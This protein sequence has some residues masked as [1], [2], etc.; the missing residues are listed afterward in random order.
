VVLGKSSLDH[1]GILEPA[2]KCGLVIEQEH[3]VDPGILPEPLDI[4]GRWLGAATDDHKEVAVMRR[5]P[6]F[7]YIWG[8]QVHP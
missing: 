4:D 8:I 2:F 3:E 1:E 6:L 7:D 5:F